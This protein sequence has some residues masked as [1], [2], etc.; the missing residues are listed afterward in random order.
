MEG[1]IQAWSGLTAEGPPE[2]GTAFFAAGTSAADM[3][4]LAW[5]LE[6]ATR[7]FYTS[8]AE[9]RPGSQEAELFLSLVQAERQ[10][11]ETLAILHKDLSPAPLERYLVEPGRRV[12]EGG[13]ELEAALQWAEGRP[14]SDVLDLALGLESNAYDRYL[15]MLDFVEDDLSKDVFRTIAGEEKRHLKRLAELMDKELK[16]KNK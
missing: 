5:A 7:E 15:K 2:A 16:T 4:S 1:G 8:L 3:A 11:Q 13:M 12:M 10:H 6:E 14:V 9:K